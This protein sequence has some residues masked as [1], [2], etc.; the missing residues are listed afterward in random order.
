MHQRCTVQQFDRGGGGI[1]DD[2]VSRATSLGNRE[3]QPGPY[4]RA[5][6]EHRMPDGSSES[7][8]AGAALGT[9]YRR[10]EGPFDSCRCIHLRL[11]SQKLFWTIVTYECHD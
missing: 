7:G 5:F 2:R 10:D 3:A 11:P 4:S 1:D 9:R 6:R 8:W